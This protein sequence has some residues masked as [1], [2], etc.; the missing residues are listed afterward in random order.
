F[1]NDEID[2]LLGSMN[3]VTSCY[4]YL[5]SKIGEE[6]MTRLQVTQ[7]HRDFIHYFARLILGSDG[8]SNFNLQE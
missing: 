3:T 7:Q 2:E 1:L 5:T 8:L 6:A 4:E